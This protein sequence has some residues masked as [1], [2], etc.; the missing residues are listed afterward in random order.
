MISVV[1][2][3]MI[4]TLDSF[5]TV[6]A[7]S[8]RVVLWW[9]KQLFAFYMTNSTLL[10]VSRPHASL[11]SYVMLC[12]LV[13]GLLGIVTDRKVSDLD[14]EYKSE[15]LLTERLFKGMSTGKYI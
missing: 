9:V 4:I 3:C 12:G 15:P 14:S 10:S 6:A 5:W 8:L 13:L 2:I 1:T 11:W 7:R